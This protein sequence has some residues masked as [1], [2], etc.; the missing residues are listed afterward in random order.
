MSPRLEQSGFAAAATLGRHALSA[1]PGGVLAGIAAAAFLLQLMLLVGLARGALG[2]ATYVALQFL[3][4]LAAWLAFRR[5]LTPADAPQGRLFAALQFQVIVWSILAGPFGAL[6]ILAYA[7]AR[8]DPAFSLAGLHDLDD[9][10]SPEEDRVE[11]LY[12]ALLDHRLRIS[13]VH[14]IRPL[15]E[16]ISQGTQIEKLAALSIIARNYRA[17]F[18]AVLKRA[19]ADSEAPVR[20]LSSTVLAELNSRFMRAIGQRL[21]AVEQD[22]G[23]AAAWGELAD[24]RLDYAASGLLDLSRARTETAGAVEALSRA[25]GIAPNDHDL[26]VRLD[27]VRQRLARFPDL[28]AGSDGADVGR[29]ATGAR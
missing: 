17:P 24:A 11:H 7:F 12:S 21:A 27:G 3:V 20:V 13:G 29:P 2:L 10:P 9:P 16:V 25:V 15:G 26:H 5:W 23:S 6:V 18:A 1:L 8:K 14:T 19:L 28:N 4:G 22:P